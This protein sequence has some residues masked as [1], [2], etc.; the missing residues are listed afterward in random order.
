MSPEEKLSQRGRMIYSTQCTACH[1]MDPKMDGSLGPA[2]AGSS[3]ELVEA[4]VMRA[5]YPD[6]YTP[7]RASKTM[8]ALPH[9]KEEIP[10]LHAFLN[11]VK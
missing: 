1:N 11:S 4:R 6:G 8:S 9:L 3:L 5:Q 7:K 10:A 2:I